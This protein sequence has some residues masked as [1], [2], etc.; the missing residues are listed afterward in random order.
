VHVFV[1]DFSNFWWPLTSKLNENGDKPFQKHQADYNKASDKVFASLSVSVLGHYMAA[2]IKT[3]LCIGSI[4]PGEHH[5]WH[6]LR[7]QKLTTS[8]SLRA[9]DENG[10]FHENATDAA[11]TNPASG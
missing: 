7:A 3:A 4:P 1:G 11:R 10:K 6:R 2:R 5:F 9:T 8:L